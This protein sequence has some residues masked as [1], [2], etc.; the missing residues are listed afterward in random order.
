M[1]GGAAGGFG[2]ADGFT[3]PPDVTREMS[4][5]ASESTKTPSQTRHTLFCGRRSSLDKDKEGGLMSLKKEEEKCTSNP[6]DKV[7]QTLAVDISILEDKIKELTSTTLPKLSEKQEEFE[8]NVD[9]LREEIS[10]VFR[11]MREAIDE[12][13]VTLPIL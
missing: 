4:S 3:D 12:R 6:M 8:K 10:S 1:S 2:P 9:S 13:E 11:E 7:I 5:C